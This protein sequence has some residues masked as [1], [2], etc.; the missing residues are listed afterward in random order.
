MMMYHIGLNLTVIMMVIRVIYQ[1][2]FIFLFKP[3]NTAISGFAEIG[4][5]LLCLS[6]LLL[7]IEI[8]H[9]NLQTKL[10]LL[11]FYFFTCL[12]YF[13]SHNLSLNNRFTI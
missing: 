4:H 5:I 6:I 3:F 11:A 2:K 8:K 13:T 7:I 9:I 10:I 12:S 1:V